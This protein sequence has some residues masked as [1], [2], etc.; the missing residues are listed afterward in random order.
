MKHI[1]ACYSALMIGLLLPLAAAAQNDR[2]FDNLAREAQREKYYS[3]GSPELRN[4]GS[5][6]MYNSDL[7]A[8]AATDGDKNCANGR[9]PGY[10]EIPNLT[11][12]SKTRALTLPGPMRTHAETMFSMAYTNQDATMLSSPMAVSDTVYNML[13]MGVAGAKFTSYTKT[14]NAAMLRNASNQLV[15]QQAALNPEIRDV[16]V[17]GF[18]GCMAKLQENG[19]SFTAANDAC[20]ED[21]ALPSAG[22]FGA[23][24]GQV[25]PWLSTHPE[26]LH[27]S[28]N[29]TLMLT[30]MLF[31][32]P[33]SMGSP[34]PAYTTYVDSFKRIFGDMRIYNTSSAPGAPKRF[35]YQ[36]EAPTLSPVEHDKQLQ[37]FAWVKLHELMRGYC[38][39]WKSNFGVDPSSHVTFK[40]E[41]YG[42][43]VPGLF[44]FPINLPLKRSFWGNRNLWGGPKMYN[45]VA[46]PSD[47]TFIDLSTTT[48]EFSPVV[49]DI[50]FGMFLRTQD[51]KKTASGRSELE[52]N[53]LKTGTDDQS[54]Y[55]KIS[56]NPRSYATEWRTVF[57]RVVK[58]IARGRRYEIYEAARSKIDRLTSSSELSEARG[59]AHALIDSV[60]L[61]DPARNEQNLVEQVQLLTEQLAK[62]KESEVGILGHS[63]AGVYADGPSKNLSTGAGKGS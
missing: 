40:Y 37:E 28:A 36:F 6:G 12:G 27:G 35:S 48:F 15:L 34:D 16:A 62:F 20:I 46:G 42:F 11:S 49:G 58:L 52:C 39:Y 44:W 38:E 3:A 8:D 1:V 17:S 59:Y 53:V 41:D 56:S 55:Q 30:D 2:L 43:G 19:K 7:S 51:V 32:R 25:S 47:D 5:S 22:N 61:K 9:C 45:G 21:S 24:T 4:R 63:L 14:M 29:D 60:A 31:P 54:N 57:D 26:H 18:L 10:Q 33:D 50:L 23:N 13:D